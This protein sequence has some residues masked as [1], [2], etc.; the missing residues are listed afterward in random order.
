MPDPQTVAERS[1]AAMWAGD[2][3]GAQQE[4]SV[5]NVSM[6]LTQILR[7]PFSDCR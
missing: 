7:R 4:V 6:V 3:A 1:A 2:A 5:E